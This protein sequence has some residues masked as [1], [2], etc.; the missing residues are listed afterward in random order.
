MKLRHAHHGLEKFGIWL[1]VL[2]LPPATAPSVL[3]A[4][5]PEPSSNA[6][7]AASPADPAAAVPATSLPVSLGNIKRGL[8]RAAAGDGLRS[9]NQTPTFKTHVVE[10][11]R[12]WVNP[13]ASDD[14]RSPTVG[15]GGN[16]AYE[17]QLVQFPKSRNPLAQP[18]AAFNSSELLQVSITTLVQQLLAPK[19]VEGA[20][21]AARR[22]AQEAAREELERALAEYCAVQPNGGAGIF[23][24]GP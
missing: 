16:Y 14:F 7:R 1:M 22:H 9:L 4:Q 13:F 11:E 12:N 20:Q 21:S 17:M 15:G 8:A 2:A 5:P 18:Y 3:A 24:C 19:V 6:D 10:R 23:G